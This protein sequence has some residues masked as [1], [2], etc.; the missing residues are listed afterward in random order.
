[1]PCT[2]YKFA[3]HDRVPAT[4]PTND[5]TRLLDRLADGDKLTPAEQVEIAAVSLSHR[6]IY[7]LAGWAWLLPSIP[8]MH[9]ILVRT[10]HDAAFH[11]YYAPSKTALRDAMKGRGHGT[12][13]EMIYAPE[14]KSR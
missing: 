7:R 13:E 5:Y 8:G 4:P 11:P 6:G 1:M 10:R 9:R 12:I 2:P 3:L 14:R